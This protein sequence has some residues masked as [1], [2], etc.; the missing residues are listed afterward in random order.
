M[1]SR[2]IPRAA[3]RRAAGFA[4][5]LAL[6]G[7]PVACGPAEVRK[8][9]VPARGTVTYDGKPAAGALVVF[10]PVADPVPNDLDPRAIVEP[11]GTFAVSTHDARDG[12]PPGRYVVTVHD[13]K[14]GPAASPEEGLPPPP[15]APGRIPPRYADPA[16]SGLTAEVRPAAP[17]SFAFPLAR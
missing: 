6:A 8:A 15:P 14:A 3:R 2:D 11:D 13:L 4:A 17:N 16:R 5:A 7:G 1:I 9:V 12:A 10:H